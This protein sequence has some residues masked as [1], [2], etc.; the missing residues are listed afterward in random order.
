MR[1]SEIRPGVRR[2]FRLGVRREMQREPDDEIRLHL[3]L[4]TDQ[5]IREGMSPADARAEAERRFGSIDDERERFRA[6]SHRREQRVRLREW[7]DG[8]AQDLRYAYRTLRRDA[9]FTAF[10]LAIVGLGVGANATVFSL[11]NG[12]LLRPMPFRDPSHLV[13]ISNIGDDGVAEW[14]FQVN[15][16]LDVGTRN[17]SLD[18]MTGY[19]AYYGIGDVTLSRAG[20]TQRLTRIPVACNF[21][22]FLGVVPAIG[23]SFTED[24][25]RFGAAPTV[26]LTDA[27]W[28]QRFGADRSI[29]GRTITLDE[30]PAT[31]IGV[32]PPTFDF[33][34]VFAPGTSVDL[35]SAFPL[36][37]ENN[38]RGNTLA[39]V[40]RLKP[41][42]SVDRA[43]T[44]LV[45]LGK[46][47]TEEFPR[48]NTLRPKPLPLDER[49]NGKVRPAL[50][51]LAG[52]V[53]A[54]ML[55]VS[56]NLSSLQLAR[57]SARR[58]E[59]AVRLALG[60]GRGR[61]MRQA[62]TESLSLAVGG[63]LLGTVLSFAGTRLVARSTAFDIPLLARVGVDGMAL[64][65][66]VFVTV[67]TGVLIGILPALHAPSDVNDV[68]KDGPRGSTR[69]AGHAR[70]RAALVVTEIATACVLLVA[71]GLLVRS[72]L[73]VLDVELGYRPE[74][75][76]SLRIDPAKR[77]TDQSAA[78]AYMDDVLRRVR[79]I[80]GVTRAGLTDVLPFGG[81]RS[82]AVAGRSQVYDRGQYPEAFIRVVSDGYFATMGI[83]LRSGRD[84]TESD[85][86]VSERVVIVN[87]TLARTL[88]PGR[89]AVG[90]L[91]G[92]GARPQRVIGVVGDVRHGTLEHAF[93]GELYYPLRQPPDIA[94]LQL[95][96]RTDL[97]TPGLAASVRAALAPIA[98]DVGKNE[99]LPLQ[100]LVDKVASPRRF[101]VLL[102]GGFSAFALVLAALGIYALVSYG[103]SQRT[104]EIGIRLALGASVRDV[105][106]MI[107][108][109]TF[110]LASNGIVAG[111]VI[112]VLFV[113]SLSG[114]L[115]G[116]TWM[117]PIS[118]G[119]G[120]V[121]LALA[122]AAAGHFPARRASRVDPS[123]ALSEG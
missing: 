69:G 31:V 12:V 4:R 13:W 46:Q 36:T 85:V 81:D 39:V 2:L 103:V 82:W 109:T 24:E 18:G 7:L 20:E 102:L 45:A 47:L 111:S 34:S 21:F 79:A 3:Q 115:F 55:I 9:A 30:S 37:E 11:I 52:A 120:L 53:A 67:A 33:G 123:V 28:R 43:R 51:V 84:F 70:V 122:A 57:L 44:D 48:R 61:L 108:R 72:F 5:L 60:A 68:L 96:V 118:F 77:F 63:A 56:A 35:F 19:F 64:A 107:M 27:M 26:L 91:I 116:V 8:V 94:A 112:S 65:V 10:A 100:Q 75:A 54:V 58:R 66:I 76:M 97:P 87:E 29:V 15:H 119:G 49:V 98:P 25:C 59:L 93:T 121:V 83:S 86:D 50:L 80:P 14:R 99:W 22:P 32:L 1:F 92:N 16:F 117:D 89:D 41:G 23:R 90:Q 101:V 40:G 113:P 6:V 78:T 38:R 104:Q 71:S 88:W 114:M 106:S 17:R 95:V 110:V 105:R 62:L 42:V 73:R 74:G